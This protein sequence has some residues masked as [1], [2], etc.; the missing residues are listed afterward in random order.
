MC[1]WSSDVCSSDLEKNE[2]AVRLAW[3]QLEKQTGKTR[4]ELEADGYKID[5]PIFTGSTKNISWTATQKQ[6]TTSKTEESVSDIIYV[7]GDKKWTIDESDGTIT[8][9][10]TTYTISQKNA[11]GSYTCDV[12]DPNN[13]QKTSYTWN[14]KD[15]LYDQGSGHQ[16]YNQRCQYR[17]DW[18]QG[19]TQGMTEDQCR[20]G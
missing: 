6:T 15:L 8:V 11:D 17:Y 19:I 13:N 1:D 3:E 4:T 5:N 16:V 7:D 18:N 20:T 10:G 12:I 9:D 2:L 14:R